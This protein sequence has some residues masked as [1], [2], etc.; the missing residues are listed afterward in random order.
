MPGTEEAT[1]TGEE[2]LAVPIKV[3]DQEFDQAAVEA[4][5]KEKADLEKYR[6]YGRRLMLGDGTFDKDREEAVRHLMT[7]AQFEPGAIDQYVDAQ[8][9]GAEVGEEG[10]GTEEEPEV[11][12]PEP[13]P[14]PKAGGGEPDERDKMID[15]LRARLDAVE[16]QSEGERTRRLEGKLDSAVGAALDSN[17]DLGTLLKRGTE[18]NGV[19]GD[20]LRRAHFQNSIRQ[21]T[22]ANLRKR[23]A[24]GGMYQEGWLKEEADKAAVQVANEYRSVIGDPSLLGRA[25]E[26]GTGEDQLVPTEPPKKPEA[27]KGDGAPEVFEKARNYT[28][29][30]LLSIASETAGEGETRA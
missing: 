3:G 22:A 28:E 25:P 16:Q 8:K 4:L 24:A 26:T 20:D 11:T 17:K 7:D 2:Q 5:L 1:R 13:K 6:K 29:G 15:E 18:L 19:E 23:K 12:D 14:K 9:I 10:E 30:T 27:A 21:Q